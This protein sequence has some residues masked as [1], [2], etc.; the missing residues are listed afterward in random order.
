LIRM[1]ESNVQKLQYK[2]YSLGELIEK[3]HHA[4]WN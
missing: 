4:N 1:G 2:A 3:N